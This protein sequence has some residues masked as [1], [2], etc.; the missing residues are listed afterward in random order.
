MCGLL[1]YSCVLF[2]RR[3]RRG[4]QQAALSR[5]ERQFVWG[6]G[7]FV[8]LGFV[9][10]NLRDLRETLGFSL[11]ELLEYSYVF[12]LPQMAQITQTNTGEL[13]YFAEKDRLGK[14]NKRQKTAVHAFLAEIKCRNKGNF[15]PVNTESSL[16]ELCWVQPKFFIKKFACVIRLSFKKRLQETH[17]KVPRKASMKFHSRNFL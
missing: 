7:C 9:C 6:K 1:E 4:M 14:W 16:L 3:S 12:I 11:C 8:V 10:V 13:Y 15:V 2:S 17:L 5:R